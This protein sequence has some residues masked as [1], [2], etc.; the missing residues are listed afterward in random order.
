MLFSHCFGS[1]ESRNRARYWL[2]RQGFDVKEPRHAAGNP[3]SS[4]RLTVHGSF[5]EWAAAR[6][7]IDSIEHSDPHAFASLLGAATAKRWV[8]DQPA[9]SVFD[10]QAP[11]GT[12]IHF[13]PRE[14]PTGDGVAARM[15]EYMFGRWE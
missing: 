8:V 15:A 10:G 5:A 11:H 14:E 7:I 4:P 12:P 9:D 3:E 13:E 2:T 6:A 1:L